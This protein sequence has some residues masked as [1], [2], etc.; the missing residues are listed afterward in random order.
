MAETLKAVVFDYGQVL[1]YR[2]KDE[3]VHKMAAMCDA[4]YAAFRAAYDPQIAAY[5]R[6]DFTG[7][8]F[9]TRVLAPL[10]IEPARELVAALI[11]E[12]TA[13]TLMLNPDMLKWSE[14][15]RR[16]DFQTAILSNVSPDDLARMREKH[17]FNRL[18]GFAVKIFS[19]EVGIVKPDPAIYRCCLHGLR[20]LPES[21]LF[22]D[23]NEDNVQ[24]ARELGIHS[25]LFQDYETSVP[26]ICVIFSL[27]SV[28]T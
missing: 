18:E 10:G 26:D 14:V 19:T 6:G 12:D 22:I 16:S 20:L 11:A 5:D 25:Y 15:L 23:D 2:E 17:V 28:L 9:W 3:H 21:V 8:D 7:V 1:S 27:P 4:T 24:A 13:S